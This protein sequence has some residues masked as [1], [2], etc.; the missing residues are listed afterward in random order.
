M[1]WVACGSIELINK[2]VLCSF[3]KMHEPL[4]ACKREHIK[5]TTGAS[6][7]SKIDRT[8]R[9]LAPPLLRVSCVFFEG[10]GKVV[11]YARGVVQG[12]VGHRKSVAALYRSPAD[13]RCTSTSAHIKCANLAY[14]LQPCQPLLKRLASEQKI[15]IKNRKSKPKIWSLKCICTHSSFTQ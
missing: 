4:K 15:K 7:V 13:C 1:H 9:H 11:T 5:E 6:S 12:Y 8:V 10:R 3:S 14:A 2:L